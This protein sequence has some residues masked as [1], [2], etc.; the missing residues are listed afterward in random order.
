[1]DPLISDQ[2]PHILNQK[3]SRRKI[4]QNKF[5][6]LFL[7]PVKIKFEFSN[8]I[9]R[10]NHLY[11]ILYRTVEAKNDFRHFSFIFSRTM[12]WQDE[13]SAIF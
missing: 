8:P 5:V 4:P 7:L 1:M 3:M 10:V 12:Y 11:T 2:Y 9:F 13:F 6:I